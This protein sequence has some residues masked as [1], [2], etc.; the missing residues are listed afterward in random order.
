M[1]IDVSK[2]CA[3]N[4]G[5]QVGDIFVC[6]DDHNNDMWQELVLSVNENLNGEMLFD[7]PHLKIEYFCPGD[8]YKGVRYKN[9]KKRF[10]WLK[11]I[12]RIERNS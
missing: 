8:N 10:V 7:Y 1:I 12:I 3:K 2:T 6:H 9:L 11:Y 5:V 4:L